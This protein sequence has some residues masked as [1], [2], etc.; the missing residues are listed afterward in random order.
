MQGSQADRRCQVIRIL[1]TIAGDN[2]QV[3]ALRCRNAQV[4][5]VAPRHEAAIHQ[6]TRATPRFAR[7]CRSRPAID[8]R[9]GAPVIPRAGFDAHGR[10]GYR[11]ILVTR[12]EDIE[13]IHLKGNALHAHLP[14]GGGAR[15][16][17]SALG[18]NRLGDLR[19]TSLD[20]ADRERGIARTTPGGDRRD[21]LASQVHGATHRLAIVRRHPCHDSRA[22]VV[23]VAI[24]YLP[25]TVGGGDVVPIHPREGHCPANLFSGDPRHVS[26]DAVG[27]VEVERHL[28]GSLID[29][30][31]GIAH[32][33]G[34]TRGHVRLELS[35]GGRPTG[36]VHRERRHPR[37]GEHLILAGH[38][39]L[40]KVIGINHICRERLEHLFPARGI[41]LPNGEGDIGEGGFLRQRNIERGRTQHGA[42]GISLW[43]NETCRYRLI[44]VRVVVPQGLFRI[45][46]AIPR[47]VAEPRHVY[48]RGRIA[49]V[50]F[51]IQLPDV[52]YVAFQVKPVFTHF[53]AITLCRYS[54]IQRKGSGA[55]VLLARPRHHL[56]RSLAS[57]GNFVGIYEGSDRIRPSG[58]EDGAIRPQEA[59]A[60]GVESQRYVLG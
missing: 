4:E 46:Q 27:E 23:A 42:S 10:I 30:R 54:R 34:I 59:R 22:F 60:R 56:N 13:V 6:A 9:E 25:A 51:E 36:K 21:R 58:S 40:R 19:A 55:D 31:R 7:A 45:V 11:A 5:Q 12:K 29:H 24:R 1:S 16:R 43:Q 50:H 14:S 15:S 39:F 57:L 8:E 49:L 53:Q 47:R 33:A 26:R 3:G 28:R 17:H 2:L 18:A 32:H 52:G 41:L 48:R 37:K 20:V 44:I 35:G 38:G